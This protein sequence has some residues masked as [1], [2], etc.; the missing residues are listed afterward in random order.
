MLMKLTDQELKYI[1][2]EEKIDA[3]ARGL[4]SIKVGFNEKL[5]ILDVGGTKYTYTVISRMFAESEITTIN[6]SKSESEGCKR[7]IIA[8]AQNFKLNE[9]FDIIFA[10]DMIEHIVSPD[11]FFEC[12]FNHLK[13]SGLLVITTPNIACWYN[14]IFLLLGYSLANYSASLKYRIGNPLLKT[15]PN[16]HKSVFN[17]KGLKDLL[18]IYKFKIIYSKGYTYGSKNH[19]ADGKHYKLRKCMDSILPIGLREGMMVIAEKNG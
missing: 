15:S 19:T 6:I 2:G 10:N 16:E 17:V 3:M 13:N 8:D 14:R 12:S 1:T 9:K 18:E 4:S 5:K 11:A 7:H